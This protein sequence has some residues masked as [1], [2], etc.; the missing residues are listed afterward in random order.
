MNMQT[1][2][3]YPL[4]NSGIIH[5]AA[6]RKWHTNSF[7]F[8]I[9][10]TEQVDKF[11]LQRALCNIPPRF[12]TIAAGI[13]S[14]FFQF[15]V[16]PVTATP[17]ILY[18]RDVL[19][20]MTKQEINRCAMRVLYSEK[21]II[22][23]FFHAL[24]DGTGGYQFMMA[25]L[26]EYVRLKYGLIL[27][28]DASVL[29]AEEPPSAEEL[30]DDYFTYSGGETEPLKYKKVYQLPGKAKDGA[31]LYLTSKMFSTQRIL[32]AAHRYGVSL[33]VFLTAIMAVAVVEIQQ[34]HLNRNHRAKPIQIMVPVNLRKR[35]SSRSVRNFSLYALPRLEPD[36]IGLSFEELLQIV[37]RQLEELTNKEKM[38]AA[39]TT[40]TKLEQMAFM[41][42]LPLFIKCSILRVAHRLCGEQTSCISLS[43]LGAVSLPEELKPYISYIEMAL[44]PR[45]SSPYNCGVISVG[46]HCAITISRYCAEPELEE[47]FF[48]KLSYYITEDT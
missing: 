25:L 5:L 27:P 3:G 21:Q 45:I 1:G 14:N 36:E 47:H 29:L 19:L 13:T 41:K 12:P 4:D 7:R 39:M 26:A 8:C 44:T 43:N 2:K 10:L 20:P 23:E 31:K 38:A 9:T 30:A 17:S 46:D 33:T 37:K 42:V 18:Q 34:A 35:F 6:A 16:I 22:G 11:T 15:R 48:K 32:A 24:T 40:N 28:K